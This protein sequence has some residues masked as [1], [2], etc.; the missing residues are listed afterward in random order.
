[1]A[2]VMRLASLLQLRKRL[3]NNG[4]G[5]LP[6]GHL[7]VWI[8]TVQ[9]GFES[10]LASQHCKSVG[11]WSEVCSHTAAQR[12]YTI[13]HMAGCRLPIRGI[14]ELKH[15]WRFF[16]FSYRI[17]HATK[18]S[19]WTT[20]CTYVKASMQVWP[21]D[22]GLRKCCTSKVP[23]VKSLEGAYHVIKYITL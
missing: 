11:P 21:T 15:G 19:Y 17:D 10:T 6:N 2:P 7:M 22:C 4:L 20:Y 13:D 23:S 1:M 12:Y 5:D 14:G 3:K 18:D 16:M 8:A 9:T